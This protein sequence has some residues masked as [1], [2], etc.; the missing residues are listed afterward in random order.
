[1][2][3]ARNIARYSFGPILIVAGL[4]SVTTL[5]LEPVALAQVNPVWIS[6]SSLNVPSSGPTATLL[7]NGKVLVTGGFSEKFGL[8]DF[9]ELYDPATRTWTL[10]GMLNAFR[11]D[12]T[13][14][15]LPDGKVLVVGGAGLFNLPVASAELYDQSADIWS[16]TGGPI[17]ARYR[18]TATLLQNGMVLTAGGASNKEDPPS[19]LASAELYNPATG[20][21]SG[22]GSLNID[23]FD[24]TATPLPNGKV[25]VAGGSNSS[26]PSL[27]GAELYDPATGTWSG[28]GSLNIDRS[29]HTATLLP[30]GKVL[31]AGGHN[32]AGIKIDTINSA[33]LYDPATGTWSITGSLNAVRSGH[34]ATLLSNG[35]VLVVGGYIHGTFPAV[36]LNGAELYDPAT[37]IWSPTANLNTPRRGH[38]ATL[39][40]DRNVLVAGG[41]NSQGELASAE[42][43]TFNTASTAVDFTGDGISDIGIYRNGTWFIRRSSDGGF[44]TVEWGL[45]KDKPV[46]GDYDGDG[47]VDIAVYREGTWFIIRS[48]DGVAFSVGWGGGSRDKALPADY[49]GDGKTDIAV[50]RDGI[51]FILRSSDG[52]QTTVAWG[53]VPTDVPLP[54]DFDGDGKA[55]VAVYRDGIWFILRSSG[56]TTAIGWGGAAQDIPLN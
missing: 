22:T 25:L 18:H 41:D 3:K 40:P 44:T 4:I 20:T 38:T 14:T 52:G 27:S 5:A 45:P 10:T 17:A 9:A 37:G 48:S 12:H 15:L 16:T 49:D 32:F 30:N 51:W 47:K 7:A 36:T 2:K 8:H 19:S 33:E 46:P 13:A 28:T 1:M 53:G 24:H 56:G 50:Y 39:L 21:W 55:D 43:Y 6:T 35:K 42:L 23:R 11:S 31:V 54:A 26:F 29:G 34:K